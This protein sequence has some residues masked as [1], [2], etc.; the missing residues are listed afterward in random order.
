MYTHICPWDL[1]EE[2]VGNAAL[3]PSSMFSSTCN[4]TLH[5]NTDSDEST[6]EKILFGIP[7]NQKPNWL[8]SSS[9]TQSGVFPSSLFVADTTDDITV[10]MMD[11]I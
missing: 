11:M 1:G 6:S 3:D 7:H 4:K 5:A 8:V 10:Y 2:T 9:R